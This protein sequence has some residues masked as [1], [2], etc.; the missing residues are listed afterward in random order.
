[1]HG[2][3]EFEQAMN[4]QH[5][6]EQQVRSEMIQFCFSKRYAVKVAACSGVC[7]LCIFVR[8]RDA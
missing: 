5:T 7:V 2:I 8:R 3:M 4:T 6:V 1:M